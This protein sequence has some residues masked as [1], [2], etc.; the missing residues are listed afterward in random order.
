LKKIKALSVVLTIL[1]IPIF[2]IQPVFAADTDGDLVPDSFLDINGTE[3]LFDWVCNTTPGVFQNAGCPGDGDQDGIITINDTCPKVGGLNANGCPSITAQDS[4]GDGYLNEMDNCPT[5]FGKYF[6][7]TGYSSDDGCPINRYEDMDG[8]GIP[9]AFYFDQDNLFAYDVCE[10][11]P[12]V[13]SYGGCP[14][15][16]DFDGIGDT[17]DACDNEKGPISQNGCGPI[18]PVSG[19]IDGDGFANIHDNCPALFSA[20]FGGCP[21]GE[22]FALDVD[23]DTVK[24]SI[25]FCGDVK[26]E[27][28]NGGCP[29]DYDK[30]GTEDIY[31]KC[32][33]VAGTVAS[34]GCIPI[35]PEPEPEPE[36]TVDPVSVYRFFNL[37][38]GAHLYTISLEERNNIQ[39]NLSATWSYEGEKFKVYDE[40]VANS[41]STHRFF[42]TKT[43][44]HLYTISE[45]EKTTIM[46]TL[47]VFSYEGIK[48]YVFETK[49]A[50]T[51][52][53][54][55]RFFNTQNGAHLYTVSEEEKNTIISTLPKFSFEGVKF[56]VL[57]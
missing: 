25:D 38:N 5:V 19:D 15:D 28:V 37:K 23:G 8:D 10:A 53:S 54:V 4:D 56:F 21:Y 1:L 2:N 29:K 42:N 36:P 46:N 7:P 6:G 9:N 45:T 34:Y 43:G 41:K 11:T 16:T 24:D 12:G 22:D 40:E 27:V 13:I 47:P 52:L 3:L 31:D 55:Y 33:L 49:Q 26:G 20:A 35:T 51:N 57:Q 17:T 30:D 48:F 50:D 44:A 14:L 32:P 39:A 18:T